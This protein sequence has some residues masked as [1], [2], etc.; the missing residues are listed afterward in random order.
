MFCSVS[1][2][3]EHNQFDQTQN[4]EVTFN[5]EMSKRKMT[6]LNT[7]TAVQQYFTSTSVG[8]VVAGEGNKS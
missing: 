2:A 5:P 8:N 4:I 6:L 3:V 1:F 7:L